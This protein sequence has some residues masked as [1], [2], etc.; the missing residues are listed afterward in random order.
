MFKILIIGLGSIGQRHLRNLRYLLKDDVD[1]W[2]VRTRRLQYVITDQL[3]LDLKAN[4]EERYK[5]RV[6]NELEEALNE[7]PDIVFITNPTSLHIPA[8]LAAAQAGCHLFIEKPLSHNYDGIPELI[9]IVES[10]KSVCFIGYQLRFHPCVKKV[11]SLLTNGAIGKLMAVR[12]EVGEYLPDWHQYEDYRQSYAARKDLGGGVILTQIHEL[13]L[14]YD[15]FGLPRRVFAVGGHL[16][17]LEID[18][19]DVASI[20]YECD[21]ADHTLPVHVQLDYLQRPPNRKYQFIG[22]QGKIYVDLNVLTVHKIEAKSDCEKKYNFS[23]VP[24]N[25]MFLDELVHFLACVRG[26]EEPIMDARVGSAS[27]RMAL[28]AHESLNHRKLVTL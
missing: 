9:T 20:L 27:L 12:L 22:E 11:K 4:I 26:E 3:T 19:P 7:G 24:R 5:I 13:D 1:I 28:A 15:W 17:S 23:G 10:N 16:S 18:V 2:A 21:Y 14:I 25:Q 8:A 6:F